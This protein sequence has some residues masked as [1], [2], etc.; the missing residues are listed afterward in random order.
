MFI[1][2]S[3]IPLAILGLIVW[4]IV[5]AVQRRRD[6]AAPGEVTPMS[7]RRLF[8]YV[9]LFGAFIVA[10]IGLSGLLGEALSTA[11]ARRST[12]LAW[13]LAMTVVGVPVFLGL[14]RWVRRTHERDPV[15]RRTFGW[16]FYL[17]IALITSL[18]V[19]ITDAFALADGLI[20][21]VW[22][23]RAAAGL[24]VWGGA[25][26]G[27]W[28]AW[29]RLEP[30]FLPQL[31]L[32]VGAAVGLWITAI[33]AAFVVDLAIARVFAATSDVIAASS[34]T[35][36]LWLAG[37]GV[38]I[39]GA[40]WT[41]HWLRHGFTAERKEGWLVYVLLFGVLSGLI[42]AVSGAGY[43]LYLVLEWIFGDPATSSAVVH[44]EQLSAPIATVLVGLAVWWYHRAV[45][46]PEHGRARGEV[47]RVYDYLVSGVGLVT[48]AVAVTI[49]VL[50]FFSAIT[51]AAAVGGD[52]GGSNTLLAAI[53]ALLVGAPVWATAWMRAQRI[54][55]SED[56]EVASPVRRTY[57][58]G[59]FGVGGMVAFGALI[60]LL[61]VLFSDLLGERSGSIAD[62][63]DVSVALLVTTGLAA[64]YHWRVYRAEREVEP[65]AVYRDVLLVANGGPIANEVARRTHARVR[66]L[67]RTDL[68]PEGTAD[69]DA[70]V[71]AIVHA[72]GEHL[73]VIAGTDEIEVVPYE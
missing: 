60:A 30:A 66:V 28:I 53:T 73:L 69:V 36:E 19:A 27:H 35:D 26:V 59:V 18:A 38:L 71:D 16:A 32:W 9:L 6:E 65:A 3:I 44:Y 41:W 47:D 63:I 40:V 20:E 61:V 56:E 21:G 31:H 24:L 39:G 51:P 15:E 67:H 49:L 1:V 42:A 68:G 2:G 55:A 64:L 43:G 11:S 50:A 62:D 37:A 34:S 10:A 22:N 46:G 57:L 13:P 48:I 7:A 25:W 72:H 12:D 5:S 4:G 23:G 70:I 54:A 45:L 14:G 52:D 58:F 17:N 29:R 8:V 33:S